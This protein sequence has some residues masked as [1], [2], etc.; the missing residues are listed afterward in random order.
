M[1]LEKEVEFPGEE[2]EKRLAE[3]TKKRLRFIPNKKVINILDNVF[4]KK[5]GKL[6]LGV[7]F[8]IHYIHGRYKKMVDE[9]MAKNYFIASS[10]YFLQEAFAR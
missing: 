8:N 6:S 4:K 1:D 10:G 7:L 5:Y 3:I 2:V 9:I